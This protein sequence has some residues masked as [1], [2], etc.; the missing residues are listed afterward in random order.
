MSGIIKN[1]SGM[2]EDSMGSK[3]W[4]QGHGKIPRCWFNHN[5]FMPSLT[6]GQKWVLACL[7]T[8]VW[9]VPKARSKSPIEDTLCFLY[10]GKRLLVTHMSERTIADKCGLNR[11]TV[12]NAIS[13]F[14]DFGA[15]IK[16]PGKRGKSFSNLYILGFELRDKS[17]KIDRLFST[18]PILMA[19]E[20]MPADIK[21]F[22]RL[23]YD[24]RSQK[25]YFHVLPEYNEFVGTLLFSE[26][27]PLI[28]KEETMIIRL[29]SLRRQING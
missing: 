13:K 24:S 3:S 28:P 26:T 2:G 1:T 17:R 20:K 18:S 11:S 25:L 23:N 16:L 6:P 9:R 19:G 22:I 10:S 27:S 8:Y 21:D 4:D 14:D 15:A 12:C 5:D 29:D 7:T